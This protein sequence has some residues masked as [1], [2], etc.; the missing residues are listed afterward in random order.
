MLS[1]SLRASSPSAKRRRGKGPDQRGNCTGALLS[2]ASKLR[3]QLAEGPPSGRAGPVEP[4][5][6]IKALTVPIWR[7]VRNL[8]PDE[9]NWQQVGDDRLMFPADQH[10]AGEA[11][12]VRDDFASSPWPPRVISV[13]LRRSASGLIVSNGRWLGSPSSASAGSAA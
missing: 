5:H 8:L 13:S 7:Q 2:P 3:K 10:H 4:Q 1:S 9:K 6:D 12:D 11:V